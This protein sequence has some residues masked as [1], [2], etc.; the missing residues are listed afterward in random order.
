MEN[1]PNNHARLVEIASRLGKLYA[2][3]RNGETLLKHHQEDLEGRKMHLAPADGWPGKNDSER[4][5]A[6]EKIFA[7]DETCQALRTLIRMNETKQ[8]EMQGEVQGLEAERRAIEWTIREQMVYAL[9]FNRL[10]SS[11]DG[12]VEE[13]AIDDG[14]DGA[15]LAAAEEAVFADGQYPNGTPDGAQEQESEFPF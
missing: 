12:A 8:A 13:T 15:M 3:L 5:I 6:Q 11:G 10:Y 14:S 9:M 2:F 1:N 4:K 7:G